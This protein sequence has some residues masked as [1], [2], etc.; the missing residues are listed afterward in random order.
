MNREEARNPYAAES[1][2]FAREQI[3]EDV[4]SGFLADAKDATPAKINVAGGVPMVTANL[5]VAEITAL[6]WSHKVGWIDWSRP[7]IPQSNTRTTW[8][9]S[10]NAQPTLTSNNSATNV[11]VCVIDQY[12]P[13]TSVE[14]FTSTN[15]FLIN[16]GIHSWVSGYPTPDYHSAAVVGAIKSTNGA[17][18][19]QGN[20]VLANIYF[21]DASNLYQPLVDNTD[22]AKGALNCASWAAYIWNFSF[23]C[24]DWACSTVFDYY[25]S[26]SPWP[27][28]TIPSG[29]IVD[30]QTQ[31][32]N[33]AHNSLTVGGV[34][35]NNSSG[36]TDDSIDT[37]SR[38]GNPPDFDGYNTHLDWELPHVVAPTTAQ[39]TADVPTSYDGG[40][41]I[42]S[43]QVAGIAAQMSFTNP[44]L[45]EWPEA[46]RALLIC[47]ADIDVDQGRLNMNQQDDELDDRDGAGEVNAQLANQLSVPANFKEPNNA[48]TPSG[49]GFH[50]IENSTGTGTYQAGASNWSLVYS[51]KWSGTNPSS[52]PRMRVVLT[53]D[54]HTDCTEP[55]DNIYTSCNSSTIDADIDIGVVRASDGHPMA[56]SYTWY[57]NWE[58]VEFVPENG[59]QYD[60]HIS[61]FNWNNPY[62]YYGIAWN[63][64]TYGAN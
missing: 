14:Y 49:F 33:W 12:L 10:T 56:L 31:V 19:P 26:H 9:V 30:G 29:N 63:T 4:K 27:F 11:K 60:F 20:A 41:S 34:D 46:T 5:T 50:Y 52:N 17:P 16:P 48:P 15:G 1:D 45:N 44:L 28:I 36:R 3:H 22:V 42:A 35:D 25:A 53:W 55:P 13:F 23:T 64:A 43:A 7:R 39:R 51:G 58:M 62:T 61:V 32:T 24:N 38:Y 21:Y 18:V 8:Q 37:S 59:V 47:S 2:R 57:S 6:A 40:T 54:A